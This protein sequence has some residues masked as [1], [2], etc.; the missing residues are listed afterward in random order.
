MGHGYWMRDESLDCA[1]VFSQIAEL[2]AVHHRNAC[3]NSALDLKAD[4]TAMRFL[5]A[6]GQI[7]LRERRQSGI[8]YAGNSR[9]ILQPFSYA[10]RI[11][12]MG[13]Q[14]E[15]ERLQAANSKPA[16]KGRLDAAQSLAHKAQ[17]FH[18]RAIAGGK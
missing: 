17:F 15:R 3:V 6:Q 1:Q 14:P 16:F 18:Q 7:M 4:Q 9:M 10:L 12:T 8:N 11:V 13:F 5:L 2:H